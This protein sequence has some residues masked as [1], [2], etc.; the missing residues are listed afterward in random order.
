MEQE[1]IE[2]EPVQ[3]EPLSSEEVAS[4]SDSAVEEKEDVEEKQ[5]VPENDSV[6]KKV[7]EKI[8][9]KDASVKNEEDDSKEE[10]SEEEDDEH[11]E[12]ELAHEDF[13]KYTKEQLVELVKKLAKHDSPLYAAKYLNRVEHLF[14]EIKAAEV[15]E[16]KSKFIE[17]GGEEDG[18]SFKADELINR[19]EANSRLIHD[20]KSAFIRERES[21]K[22]NN[23]KKAEETLEK[24]REFV[25]SEE[26]SASFNKFKEIQSE[27]KAIGD[28]PGQYSKTLWA[29]YNALVSR[30]YDQRSIY[31]ELKELD[32]KK[33]YEAK[34]ELCERAEK[35]AEFDNLK[36][37]ITS[38][39]ELHEEFKHIGPVPED[40]QE[41]LWL[42]FK[43][44]SDAVY[45]RRKEFISDLKSELSDNLV[46]KQ[47]LVDKIKVFEEFES[48]RIK[49]WNSKTKEI[50][51]IQKD[52]EKIGGLPRDKSKEI[53]RAFWSSFKTFFHNKG[54]FF[55]KLDE[56]RSGNYEE[57]L[58]LVEQAEALK[59]STDWV[60]TANEFKELQK[61]WKEIG[62]VPEKH[63][64]EI[65]LKFK[66]A[67]DQF[68]DNRRGS[69]K[70]EE[71]SYKENLKLK[72]EIVDQI[73]KWATSADEHIE[74]LKEKS[75]EFAK[76]GFVPRKDIKLIKTQ[77]SEAVDK[78]MGGLS[79]PD[80]DKSALRAEVELGDI[81]ASKNSDR[82]LY[83][84]EQLIRKQ[85]HQIE[86]DV[87][88]WKNNLEFFAH[89]KTA[90]SL[91]EEVNEKIEQAESKIASLKGQLRVLRSV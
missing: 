91:R 48:D 30:F 66:A 18:F 71:K 86:N 73:E 43:A 3:S 72:K 61:K 17:E 35:L 39:N 81:L 60:K 14:E 32:R 75:I 6:E 68:F 49:A 11:D 20:R 46:K 26:S 40:V 23:L 82:A 7:E 4:K 83:H 24:L 62:P 45:Q 57:K 54:R 10:N 8:E 36:E 22:Q 76:V 52:W 9:A 42:R 16:A 50:L 34:L 53:N 87:A 58:K 25:D 13:E 64:N 51:E 19:F 65:Y 28:V 79:I 29:N 84:K 78:F 90:D 44:A 56:Q 37:A 41:D 85:I 70:E 27:W 31:F 2:Q 69:H 63:R 80:E 12:D 88:L 33:N 47:E 21:Q 67:C 89:S 15:E 74:D 77:F 38:L 59:E 5:V 55:K 1:K